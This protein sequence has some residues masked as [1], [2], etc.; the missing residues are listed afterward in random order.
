MVSRDG[1]VGI[2]TGYGMDGQGVGVRVP[3]GSQ[4]FSPRRPDGFWGSHSLQWLPGETFSGVK[5]PRCEAHHS[6]STS[7]EV[8]NMW[9]YT[10]APPYVFHGVIL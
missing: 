5:W 9:I 10:S 6:P 7:A 2:A 8:K 3:V 1:A 4:I